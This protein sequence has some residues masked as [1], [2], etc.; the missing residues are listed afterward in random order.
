M[1]NKDKDGKPYGSPMVAYRLEREDYAALKRLA[2]AAGLKPSLY[3]K[4]VMRAH[5]DVSKPD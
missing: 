4:R 2:K 1:A 5:V 3:A